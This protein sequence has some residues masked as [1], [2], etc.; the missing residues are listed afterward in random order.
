ML[1]KSFLKKGF[2]VSFTRLLK[3][4]ILRDLGNCGKTNQS[5]TLQVPLVFSFVSWVF[6]NTVWKNGKIL[7]V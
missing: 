1:S 5:V 7:K 4:Q 6:P 3:D 2:V